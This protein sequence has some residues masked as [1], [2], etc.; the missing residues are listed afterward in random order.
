MPD[1]IFVNLPVKDLNASRQFYTALGFSVNEDFCDETAVSIVISENIHVMLLTYN[2]F[3]QFTSKEISDAT[4]TTEVLNA[5][6]ADSRD[7][8]DAMVNAALNAGS[9]EAS[10]TQDF[11]FMY[12]RSFQDP[13]GHI[14]E[15]FWMDTSQLPKE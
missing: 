9:K 11:G 12:G 14:W 1:K 8:V 6:S 5:L 4:K 3:K 13:D 2:K 15:V 10:P 7:E